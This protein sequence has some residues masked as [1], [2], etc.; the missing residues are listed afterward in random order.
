MLIVLNSY[1]RYLVFSS[2]R[3]FRLVF[4]KI[5]SDEMAFLTAGSWSSTYWQYG[6]ML[7]AV[8][9]TLATAVD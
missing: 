6:S 1:D 3:A 2:T 7:G 5:A 9:L 4:H 8:Y